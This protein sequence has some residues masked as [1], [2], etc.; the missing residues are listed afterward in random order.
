MY[1]HL[2]LYRRIY[3]LPNGLEFDFVET[4]IQIEKNNII[5]VCTYIFL[6]ELFSHAL[7][8]R[9]TENS[10]NLNCTFK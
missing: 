2:H 3:I 10:R 8:E 9:E 7:T 5:Y 4:Y 6:S 1:P